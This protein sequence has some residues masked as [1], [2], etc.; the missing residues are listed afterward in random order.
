MAGRKGFED[1]FRDRAVQMCHK[2]VA[3]TQCSMNAARKHVA[4]LVGVSAETLRRW[5]QEAEPVPPELEGAAAEAG[6][7]E[8]ENAEP[9]GDYEIRIVVSVKPGVKTLELRL[10]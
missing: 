8:R 6:R 7:P 3:D 1:G 2:Y 10:T 9:S 5:I 4:E